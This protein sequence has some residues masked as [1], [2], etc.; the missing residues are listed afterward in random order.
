MKIFV[1]AF[2]NTPLFF[3]EVIKH[4][5][6]EKDSIEWGVIFPTANYKEASTHLVKKENI[7]YLYENFNLHYNN[8]AYTCEKYGFNSSSDNIHR[9]IEGSK[10]GYKKHT[11]E[12]QEKNANIIY[13]LYKEYLQKARPDYIIFPDLE[14]V[15]GLI[16]LNLCKELN[17][18]ILY[19]VH[20]RQFGES[21]FAQDYYDTFPKYY[22]NYEEIDIE[23]SNEFLEKLRK[24][25]T[26]AFEIRNY[27]DDYHKIVLPHIIYRFFKGLYN[28]YKYEKNAIIE[29]TFITKL[30]IL[31]PKVHQ[32]YLDMK[33]T[34]FQKKYFYINQNTKSTIPENFI[35]FP[36]Q[37]T[38]E[39][40]IN[41]LEQYFIDQEK[42]IDMVRLNMPHNFFLLVKEHPKMIGFRETSFYKRIANK[43]GVILVDYQ[44]STPELLTRSKLI[45]TVTGTIGLESYLTNKKAL[46]FG[47]TFFS[48]LCTR[49]DSYLNFRQILSNLI[50]ND[51]QKSENDIKVDIAKIYNISHDF[52]LNDPLFHPKIMH[53]NNIINFLDAVKNHIQRI[54]ND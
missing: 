31:F 13:K 52:V 19:N 8:P 32:L 18:E 42:L 7:F 9:M 39:S 34:F 25:Q 50:F 41:T 10:H 16:L 28:K 29:V 51:I 48:H 5:Q 3:N 47:P 1:Y 6:Q 17:I 27:G 45:V 15:D 46:M 43:T 33:Y 11:R 22:G 12:V 21:F 54:N 24:N 35:L 37:M 44:M 4:S 20:T 14:V 23:K 53:V 49:F 2:A 38:P 26:K 30:L 36:L 40:S